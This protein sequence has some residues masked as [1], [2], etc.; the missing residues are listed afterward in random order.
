MVIFEIPHDHGN[1]TIPQYVFLYDDIQLKIYKFELFAVT[2]QIFFRSRKNHVQKKQ[3]RYVPE[4]KST[5]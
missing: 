3:Q 1:L 2:A 5:D 4:R